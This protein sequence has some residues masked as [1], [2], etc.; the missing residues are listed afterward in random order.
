MARRAR[1]LCPCRTATTTHEYAWHFGERTDHPATQHEVVDD[2]QRRYAGDWANIW[3]TIF[4]H[5]EAC[6]VAALRALDRALAEPKVTRQG[7]RN[8]PLRRAEASHANG[9]SPQ[10]SAA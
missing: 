5:R 2:L 10:I 8:T 4:A 7:D 9:S 6:M 3:S 1:T